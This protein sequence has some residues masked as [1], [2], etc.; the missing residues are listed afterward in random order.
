MFIRE[1]PLLLSLPR[2][3]YRDAQAGFSGF[4][5]EREADSGIRALHYGLHDGQPK[6]RSGL[7]AV[8]AS[9]ERVEYALALLGRY[10]GPVSFIR[11]HALSRSMPTKRS[12]RPPYGV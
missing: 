3:P 7:L 10:T 5:C 9:M 12:I 4:I 1:P 2:Q 6:T 11:R 8:Q